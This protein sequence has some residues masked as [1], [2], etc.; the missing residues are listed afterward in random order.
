MSSSVQEEIND[1][2]PVELLRRLNKTVLHNDSK[3]DVRHRVDTQ[4]STLTFFL[5]QATAVR[6]SELGIGS[7]LGLVGK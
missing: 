5:F 4:H 1:P 6:E 7:S 2:N 3:C